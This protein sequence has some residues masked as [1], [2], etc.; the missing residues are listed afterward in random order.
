VASGDTPSAL[1]VGV[2]VGSADAD[3]PGVIKGVGALD[4]VEGA[5]VGTAVPVDVGTAV[6]FADGDTAVSGTG[7]GS[8]DGIGVPRSGAGVASRLSTATVN[9]NPWRIPPL[10]DSEAATPMDAVRTRR[11][12]SRKA[13]VDRVIGRCSAPLHG[14]VGDGRRHRRGSRRQ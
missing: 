12:P 13:S 14:V 4:G 5:G 1:G 11:V 8:G 2:I 6:A 3:P 9:A 7:E 10:T